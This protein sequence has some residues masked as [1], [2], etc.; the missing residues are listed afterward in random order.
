MNPL[1]LLPPLVILLLGFLW[2]RMP[3]LTRPDIFF[4]VTVNPGFRYTPEALA[5]LRKYNVQIC[6]HTA[7]A[8]AITA[9]SFPHSGKLYGLAIGWQVI[10]PLLFA[11]K[12]ANARTR[13]F[14]SEPS[15]EF[16]VDLSPY[17][18]PLPGGMLAFAIPLVILA[19][20]AAIL[21]MN[22]AQIPQ[23]F[24]VHWGLDG[25]PNRWVDRTPLNVYGF[26]LMGG[27]ICLSMAAMASPML[28]SR[29]ISVTGE[30]GRNERKFRRL[31]LWTLLL[32][33][34]AIAFSFGG[35]PILTVLG[36]TSAG[37]VFV[38][39]TLLLSGVMVAML[40]RQGQ[41]GSRLSTA[42]LSH[43]PTGDRTP[44]NCW[45]WGAFYVNPDDP[46]LFVEKRFGL[47]YTVNL[48][49]RWSWVLLL[50][51]LVL[52]LGTILLRR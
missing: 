9:Y 33:E 25:K 3:H 8:L 29:R 4:S 20:S 45:K 15:R 27:L 37:P 46:A 34:Y 31:N 6:L 38:A 32:S 12:S 23:P 11:L 39:V 18:E 52:P 42:N 19:V 26:L 35:L 16:E 2:F 13:P 43:N 21:Y 36:G 49:N 47:G 50:T 28:R 48:G 24:P 10:G 30:R 1:L 17:T 51:I 7:I 44:D 40:I 22:W 41:G 14:A 5:I